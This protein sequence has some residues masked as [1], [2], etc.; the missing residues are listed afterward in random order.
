[1][2][3]ISNPYFGDVVHSIEEHLTEQDY[4][5]L[6]ADTHDN[7]DSEKRAVGDL[8]RQRPPVSSSFRPL[9]PATL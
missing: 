6:L 4:S 8:L 7:P 1:M 3:A 2:S 5:P 9:P